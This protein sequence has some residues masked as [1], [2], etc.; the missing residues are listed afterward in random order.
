MPLRSGAARRAFVL[1]IA[2]ACIGCQDDPA[3]ARSAGASD[4]SFDE[5]MRIVC[6]AP[7]KAEVSDSGG[8]ANRSMVLA[9]WIDARVRNPEVR[10]LMT[11]L[12]AQEGNQG[13][14]AALESG[15]RRAGIA[16]CKLAELWR[17]VAGGASRAGASSAASAAAT[18]PSEPQTYDEAIAILCDAARRANLPARPADPEA[19]D[20]AIAHHVTTEISNAEVRQL[21]DSLRGAAAGER[22][23]ELREAAR[24]SGLAAC[25]LADRWAERQK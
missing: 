7:D 1:S 8:E 24:K 14:I 9:M 18:L 11:S 21:F 10:R 12:A 5:A 2:L 23:K 4:Q 3:P 16:P 19:D 17:T 6:D 20:A 22:V 25:A 15:A 13:K